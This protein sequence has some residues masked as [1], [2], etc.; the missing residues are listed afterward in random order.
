M[1]SRYKKFMLNDCSNS[2]DQEHIVQ[3]TTTNSKV[4]I[5]NESDSEEEA[6]KNDDKVHFEE[7]ILHE[8]NEITQEDPHS[9]NEEDSR[10]TEMLEFV[11][12][13]YANVKE[14]DE[15]EK[16]EDSCDSNKLNEGRENNY[17]V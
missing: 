3:K 8:S 1:L 6:F 12:T 7:D 11:E 10:T 5:K 17:E 14:T 16:E 4:S 13:Q 15:Y 9:S 2:S